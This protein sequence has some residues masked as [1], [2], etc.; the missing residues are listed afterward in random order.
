LP[1]GS[2]LWSNFDYLSLSYTYSWSQIAAYN[3]AYPN[4]PP[5]CEPARGDWM[6]LPNRFMPPNISGSKIIGGGATHNAVGNVYN[7]SIWNQIIWLWVDFRSDSGAITYLSGVPNRV[8]LYSGSFKYVYQNR[9]DSRDGR[10][11]G[12]YKLSTTWMPGT[13]SGHSGSHW[14]DFITNSW[15][16]GNAPWLP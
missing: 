12:L 11:M 2:I 3:N 6:Y 1:G 4:G 9:W 5:S 16:S 10:Q 13:P 7:P 8:D 14:Y 15:Q